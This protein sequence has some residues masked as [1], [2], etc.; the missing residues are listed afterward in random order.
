MNRRLVRTFEDVRG[1]LLAH[2]FGVRADMC[3]A[4][5]PDYNTGAHGLLTIFNGR[6]LIP[7]LW[8]YLPT[9]MKDQSRFQLSARAETVFEK[10]MFQ[11]PVRN[12]R[13]VV[14]VDAY[15][16]LNPRMAGAGP[17]LVYRPNRAPFFLAGLF[18]ENLD[19]NPTVAL[20][21]KP[22]SSAMHQFCE[23]MP[24]AF[25]DHIGGD[26]WLAAKDFNHNIEWFEQHR[27]DARVLDESQND[28]GLLDRLPG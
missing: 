22:A 5:P 13:C 1:V 7:G 9:W 25:E 10:P 20:L 16:E 6:A 14:P 26:K 8:G 11:G 28:P 2:G 23:R 15:V 27:I 12:S 24:V 4:V 3:R 19:G 17:H 18:T 21:T